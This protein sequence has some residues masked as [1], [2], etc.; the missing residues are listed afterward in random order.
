MYKTQKQIKNPQAETAIFNSRV[1]IAGFIVFLA[2]SLIFI[3]FFYLQII[4][5]WF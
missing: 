4:K 5:I 2:L 1:I 3:R